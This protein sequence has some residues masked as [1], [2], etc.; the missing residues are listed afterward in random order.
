MDEPRK[1]QFLPAILSCL[2]TVLILAGASLAGA[3]PGGLDGLVKHARDAVFGTKV[4]MDKAA[5]A[6]AAEDSE[7]TDGGDGTDEG[8][9]T[10]GGSGDGS[11]SGGGVI[12]HTAEDCQAAMAVGQD[13][14]DSG[15]GLRHAIVVVEANCEKNPQA[16]GL[17]NAL[18][19]L[20]ENQGEGNG[21]GNGGGGQ[22]QGGEGQGGAGQG[23]AGGGQGQGQGDGG[24]PAD[25]TDQGKHTAQGR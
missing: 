10:D 15:T 12:T 14:L 1:P 4:V 18:Q 21:G 13:A 11:G 16:Q 5:E 6:R 24:Q 17:L 7:G 19:H 9:G 8:D 22:G 3:A 2:M 23:Q 20:V 25:H